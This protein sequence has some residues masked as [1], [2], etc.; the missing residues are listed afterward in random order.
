VQ[1]PP[2]RFGPSLAGAHEPRLVDSVPSFP[3]NLQWKLGLGGGD[4]TTLGLVAWGFQSLEPAATVLGLPW[5]LQV[6]GWQSFVLQG[7]PGQIG[8]ATWRLPLPND[9]SLQLQPFYFQLF[10][11]DALATGGIAASRGYEFYLR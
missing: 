9:P 4:G 1:K 7:A 8:H 3:G 5:Q 10:A 2:R 11:V 6:A